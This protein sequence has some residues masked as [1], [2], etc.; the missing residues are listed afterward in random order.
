VVLFSLVPRYNRRGRLLLKD[1]RL[2]CRPAHLIYFPFYRKGLFL[3][4]VNSNH[5]IQHGTVALSSSEG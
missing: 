5:S 1:V 4:E 3:R 2:E